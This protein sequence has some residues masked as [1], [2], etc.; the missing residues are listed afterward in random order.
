MPEQKTI[1]LIDATGTTRAVPE[2]EAQHWLDRGWKAETGG[3]AASRTVAAAKEEMYGG[4][5]GTI[6]STLAGA[7]RTASFGLTDVAARVIGGEDARLELEG[8]RD[9][10]QIASLVGEIGGSFTGAGALANRLGARVVGAGGSTA[11]QVGRAVAGGTIEGGLGGLSQGVSQVALSDGPLSAENI[12]ST[13]SSNMLLGGVTGGLAGGAFKAGERALVRAGTV[14]ESAAN[15]RKALDDVPADLADLDDAGL[16]LAAKAAKADHAA[17]VLA[18]R[19]SLEALRVEQRAELA[20]QVKDFHNELATA[21][22]IHTAVAGDDIRKAIP[23]IGTEVAAPLNKSYRALRAAYDNPIAVAENPMSLLKPLQMQQTALENLRARTPELQA[24]L[25]GDS[26]LAAL[27]HVEFALEQNKAFQGAIRQ[28]D[29][30]TP[31][32]GSRLSMLE[33]GPSERMLQIEKAREA[34]KQAPELGM[35]ARGA[36]AGA[37]A[38]GT[39]LATMVPGMGIAAPFLGKMASDFVGKAAQGLAGAERAVAQKSQAAL[40]AFLDTSEKVGKFVP[41]TATAVL[42]AA[43]FAAG[44][45]P[46]SD[47]L[48]D[49][50]ATRSAE[51]R[52]QTHYAPDG[53]VQMRPDARLAMAKQLDPIRA[54]NPMLADKVETTAAAKVAY[55]SSKLPRKPEIGGL[56][57]G[58]DK[59]QPSDLQMRSWARTVRAVEDPGGVEERLLHGNIT[60]EDG[61]AYRTVYPE[62][63]AALQSAIFEAAPSLAKTLPMKRKIALSVFTGVP[64]IPAL[65]PNVLAVLQGNFASEAGSAGGTQS[66]QPEPQFGKLGSLKSSEKP[67]AAQAREST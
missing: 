17:D 11:A 39:A 42:K 66:P 32:G 52:Q 15:A 37:F 19:K 41:R 40:R 46:K 36:K 12:A 57:I 33:G 50:Y 8:L 14:L 27:D 34:L 53:S 1:N 9:Q 22:P 20:N 48:R 28:L 56:Q 6:K 23:G 59:W 62:R 51:I 18:E 10:N 13:L 16:V 60:P 26:R 5:G 47:D 30:S 43:R 58:P 65:Q 4:V 38:G 67:T 3:D 2:A 35:L 44:P 31:L 25:V 54:V 45:E 63:F 61:E 64:L 21:R 24:A 29:K 7:A 55:M 49:L